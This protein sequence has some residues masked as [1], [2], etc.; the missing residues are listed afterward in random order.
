MVGPNDRVRIIG[1]AKTDAGAGDSS[2]NV[3]YVNVNK[4]E[5]Q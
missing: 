4:I 3:C 1:T 2:L 5:K